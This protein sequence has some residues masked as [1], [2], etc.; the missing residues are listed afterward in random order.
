M[1][2]SLIWPILLSAISLINALIIENTQ[3]GIVFTESGGAQLI[4]GHWKI[5]YYYNLTEYYQEV[6]ELKFALGYLE[7]TCNKLG[8]QNCGSILG[9]FN[10]EYEKMK[11]DIDRFDMNKAVSK[12]GAPL[13]FMG[14]FNHYLTGVVDEAT[15]NEYE[16]KI[17]E[18]I[19]SVNER[20]TLESNKTTFIKKTLVKTQNVTNNLIRGINEMRQEFKDV[21]L[22]LTKVLDRGALGIRVNSLTNIATLIILEHRATTEKIMNKNPIDLIEFNTI[23]SDFKHINEKLGT[24][25]RLP[26]QVKTRGDVYKILGI[27]STKTGIS[28]KTLLLEIVIPLVE[29]KKYTLFETTPIPIIHNGAMFGIKTQ[30]KSIL[31]SIN[32][33]EYVE[34]T[35]N[36]FN[37]CQKTGI[38]EF[39]CQTSAPIVVS[40]FG[41]CE[42]DILFDEGGEFPSSCILKKINNATYI[43]EMH[44]EGVYIVTPNGPTRAQTLC[45][46][47]RTATSVIVTQVIITTEPGCIIKLGKYKLKQNG[48]YITN[49]THINNLEIN[50]K[51]LEFDNITAI[52][53][54]IHVS[55]VT[56]MQNTDDFEDLMREAEKIEN[57]EKN[58]KKID[59]LQTDSSIHSFSLYGLGTTTIIIIIAI[60]YMTITVICPM[61]TNIARM[62]SHV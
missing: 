2:Q 22:N 47:S 18:L 34:I 61:A 60:G 41:T 3:R 6:Q 35:E 25:H 20:N 55:G 27:S 28:S 53:R 14:T 39:I 37:K 19:K 43:S 38:A 8:D 16:K 44:T 45:G 11:R 46:E 58:I 12:R 15:A 48:V 51:N 1:G 26:I 5:C 32:R 10:S 4:N 31:A 52:E 23:N 40:D 50:I 24:D 36:E 62:A 54:A 49:H 13:A 21:V 17:N 33:K 9:F 56:I 29:N 42:A 30:R 57:S 59:E 7:S